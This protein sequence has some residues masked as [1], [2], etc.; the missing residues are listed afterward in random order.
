MDEKA[1]IDKWMSE[2]DGDEYC[3]YCKYDDTCPHGWVCYGDSTIEPPCCSG[4]I[5]EFL[6]VE[7]ILEDKGKE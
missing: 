4:N 3:K 5:K 6:N 7:K 1:R 2:H